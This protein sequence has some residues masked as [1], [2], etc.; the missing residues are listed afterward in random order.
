[1]YINIGLNNL[2][3]RYDVYQM[4]NIFYTFEDI[5]F[6]EDDKLTFDVNI[7]EDYLKIS[8]DNKEYTYKISKDKNFKEELKKGIFIYLTDKLRIIHPWGTLVG[9]R[10]SK[11]ALKLLNEGK[12]EK[13]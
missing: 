5:K 8:E 3:Y 11:I 1:M 10:P 13:K 2:D 12:S 9:I 7:G 4:F 6:N